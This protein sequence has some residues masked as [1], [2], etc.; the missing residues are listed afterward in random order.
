[1]L[2]NFANRRCES[3]AD[4]QTIRQSGSRGAW[5]FLSEKNGARSG[6]GKFAGLNRDEAVFDFVRILEQAALR[7][8]PEA[9]EPSR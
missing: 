9:R 8:E 7:R 5:R 3:Q 6:V 4:D 1:M 2:G